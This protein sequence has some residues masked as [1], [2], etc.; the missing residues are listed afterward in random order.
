[1]RWIDRNGFKCEKLIEANRAKGADHEQGAVGKI[2]HAQSSKDEC[3]AKGNQG[4]SPTFVQPVQDLKQESVH[5]YTA[6][7]KEYFWH[8]PVPVMSNGC[9]LRAATVG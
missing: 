6:G 5:I 3:Q 8:L 4:I 1:M 7:C 9:S 2:H